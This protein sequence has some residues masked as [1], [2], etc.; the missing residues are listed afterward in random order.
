ME[1]AIQFLGIGA[2]RSGSSWLWKQLRLHDEIWMPPVKE[3]H[4]F[5]RS[6]SY[7][8]PSYLASDS[9][10]KRLFGRESRNRQFRRRLF[11]ELVKDVVWFRP[12]NLSWTCRYFLE[13]C[14][15]EWYKSLFEKGGSRLKGEIT[16]AYSI[17]EQED[18]VSIAES[19]PDLKVL[20]LIRNPIYRAW[21]HAK[22]DYTTGKI[23][24]LENVNEVKILVDKPVQELR[25]DYLRTYQIWAEVF[26]K[27]QVYVGFYDRIEEDPEGLLTEIGDFLGISSPESL[28]SPQDS[29]RRVNASKSTKIPKQVRLCLA[30]KYTED[31]KALQELFGSYAEEWV[32]EAEA[33]L[34]NGS[35]Q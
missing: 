20:F 22:Y 7:P 34:A 2:A 9:A 31:L 33:V 27:D 24:D 17:L 12:S 10:F 11:K 14:S 30:R 21:S 6:L 29:Q 4:Y 16:P 23:S 13:P 25:S 1:Q 32:N 8:S 3:L 28:F 18:V 35:R 19:F 15:I 26:G 5:D